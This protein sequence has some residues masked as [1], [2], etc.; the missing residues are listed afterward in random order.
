MDEKENQSLDYELSRI[1]SENHIRLQGE[2]DFLLHNHKITI[3]LSEKT[4]EYRL[5]RPWKFR[6]QRLVSNITYKDSKEVL[7]NTGIV[8]G[9]SEYVSQALML[10]LAND[11]RDNSFLRQIP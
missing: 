9:D 1:L 7:V 4:I 8:D 3:E 6:K 10:Y 11:E 2:V 5:H